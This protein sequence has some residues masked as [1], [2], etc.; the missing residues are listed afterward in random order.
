MKNSDMKT[1]FEELHLSFSH[2]TILAY[3]CHY[4]SG[5]PHI[6]LISL[7]S[8]LGVLHMFL[9]PILAMLY[10]RGVQGKNSSCF[11]VADHGEQQRMTTQDT[12]MKGKSMKSYFVFSI[13]SVS[14]LV[15]LVTFLT[16]TNYAL[17][18]NNT[19]TVLNTNLAVRAVISLS[20]LLAIIFLSQLNNGGKLCNFPVASLWKRYMMAD[21]DDDR[22]YIHIWCVGFI[23]Y[24]IW[25]F[26]WSILT[27]MTII[28]L[29]FNL[30]RI[31]LKTF[32][33]ILIG[34]TV[35]LS[36]RLHNLYVWTTA[37]TFDSKEMLYYGYLSD[38]E[39]IQ[40]MSKVEPY[41][42]VILNS[43][44][45]TSFH[46]YLFKSYRLASRISLLPSKISLDS[47]DPSP[48]VSFL[49]TGSIPEQFGKPLMIFEGLAR[50]VSNSFPELRSD[51]DVMFVLEHVPVYEDVSV[52]EEGNENETNG[53]W[54]RAEVMF[55]EGKE[56]FVRI[57]P[58]LR[59]TMLTTH[60]SNRIASN[61]L[62]EVVSNSFFKKGKISDQLK[63]LP[64][65]INSREIGESFTSM[66]REETSNKVFISRA[67]PSVNMKV[68]GQSGQLVFD[69][70]FLLSLPV[71]GWP[72]PAGEWR[73]RE[74][75]WPGEEMVDWLVRLPC[76]LIPKPVN[77]GDQKTWRFSFSRQEV[78]LA[79]ILPH[80]ARLCYVG[81]K[82]IFKKYLKS[83][84]SGLKSY[85][86]LTLFFWFMERQDP[87]LWEENGDFPFN[88]K[89][90]SLLKF[91]AESLHRNFIPHYFIRTINLV[92]VMK[93]DKKEA[94]TLQNV[95][96]S[97]QNI[98]ATED[99]MNEYIYDETAF[100]AIVLNMSLHK[101]V[102]RERCPSFDRVETNKLFSNTVTT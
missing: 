5:G 67:G 19:N 77:E 36:D 58:M 23:W 88:T 65:L 101:N 62:T 47:I 81:L 75:V 10:I 53:F 43:I 14:L 20:T 66:L 46:Q 100:H 79:K 94:N 11:L 61:F 16:L 76:H 29:A 34:T 28:E 48:Q 69:C 38:R 45:K 71:V 49:H 22:W 37:D 50:S 3:T 89:L 24:G 95:A 72:S 73:I 1:C 70:D 57:I 59:D 18:K 21:Y 78:E 68:T 90:T 44:K 56:E 39:K 52:N 55:E 84:Y 30:V 93:V 91:V 15:T 41:V 85:H 40:W 17:N 33:Y 12:R 99:V 27:I 63:E 7:V 96:K 2:K 102:L 74:R 86:I 60:L 80:N 97:I 98:I 42:A 9:P 87:R 51:H 26:F 32:H 8:L 54:L 92:K 83:T 25:L 13:L 6:F 64:L 4:W 31:S 35:F 82:H